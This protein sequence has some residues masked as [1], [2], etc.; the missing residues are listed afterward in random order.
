VIS[1]RLESKGTKEGCGGGTDGGV[2][3]TV[4]GCRAGLRRSI[5]GAGLSADALIVCGGDT[6]PKADRAASRNFPMI[7]FPTAAL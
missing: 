2:L 1:R 6:V 7:A 4:F 5:A 3:D